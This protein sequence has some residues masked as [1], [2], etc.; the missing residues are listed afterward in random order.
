[1]PVTLNFPSP[2]RTGGGGGGGAASPLQAA[3]GFFRFG[4]FF[5]LSLIALFFLLFNNSQNVV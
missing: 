2:G 3:R 5:S 4:V 1:M